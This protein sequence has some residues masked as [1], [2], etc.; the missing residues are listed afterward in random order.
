[1]DAIT[2]I[3]SVNLQVKSWLVSE[4]WNLLRKP[5]EML[6]INPKLISVQMRAFLPGLIRTCHK[7]KIGT[8]LRPTSVAMVKAECKY[9]MLYRVVNDRHWPGSLG[10]HI[11]LKG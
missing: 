1:M 3:G 2:L 4:F 11:F 9:A 8:K 7:I 6:A 5:L 10:S